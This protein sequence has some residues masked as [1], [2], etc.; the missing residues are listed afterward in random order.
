MYRLGLKVVV[1]DVACIERVYT[2][3]KFPRSKKNRIKKKWVKNPR[4]FEYQIKHHIL[5]IRDTLYM[6][7]KRYEELRESIH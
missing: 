7:T 4:N 5:K 6:S 1:D 2:Q 3:V